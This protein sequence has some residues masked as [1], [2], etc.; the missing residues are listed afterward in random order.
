MRTGTAILVLEAGGDQW[1]MGYGKQGVVDG[2]V[3]SF[4]TGRRC[5]D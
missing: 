2:F 5:R 3:L 4:G 1:A